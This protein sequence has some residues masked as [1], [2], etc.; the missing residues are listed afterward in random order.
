MKTKIT[1]TTIFIS[2]CYLGLAQF[3]AW[4]KFD[5]TNSGIPFDTVKFLE[6]DN[7]G[8][9]WYGTND[10]NSTA[11]HIG[12][13]NGT[14]WTDYLSGTN[15]VYDITLDKD[16]LIWTSTANKDLKSWDGSNWTT[17]HNEDLGWYSDPIFID[18]NGIK[19]LN[20]TAIVSPS[21]L[22]F[23][24]T[25][26]TK[27]TTANSGLPSTNIYCMTGDG[28]N[29]IIGTGN[30]GLV[31]FDGIDWTVY[32][33]ANSG[34]TSNTIY[35]IEF[36]DDDTLW[37]ATK[38]G[39]I[40]TFKD[41]VWNVHHSEVIDS[42]DAIILDM[43]FDSKGNLWVVI[44]NRIF[45]YDMQTWEEYNNTNSLLPEHSYYEL[46]IDSNDKVW[47]GTEFGIFTYD[48]AILNKLPNITSHPAN[49]TVTAGDKV[50]MEVV[51][52]GEDL[53]YQWRRNDT[54]I[55]NTDASVYTINSVTLEHGG[56][57][58]CIVNNIYSSDTSNAGILVVNPSTG[59]M[60]RKLCNS[61]NIYPNPF[62]NYINLDY[63]LLKNSK[64]TLRIYDITGQLISTLVD[65]FQGT[66][67]YKITF[68]GSDLAEG[69]YYYEL[70]SNN[71]TS[72]GQL[73]KVSQ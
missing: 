24:D 28:Q 72:Y 20:P 66:G 71:L 44:S 52:T 57:Y 43:D 3:P 30:S 60:E 45:K 53:H 47:I 40:I 32:N 51:A 61:I 1:L 41:S 54:D 8:N 12:F 50:T 16:G 38:N 35:K 19:W 6:I 7:Q 63:S 73:I 25:N 36:D 55:V 58:R 39:D 65:E 4:E 37:I 27:F 34:L 64:V 22:S 11:G 2:L 59:I 68:E 56:V 17:Y 10:P 13:Y 23:N 42:L 5:Q 21:L 69:V 49:Q 14:N 33:T 15:W 67:D 62:T 29:L 46:E 9:I 18:H 70:K 26:W 48:R 31:Y